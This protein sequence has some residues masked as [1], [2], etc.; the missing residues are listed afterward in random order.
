MLIYMLAVSGILIH[1]HYCG[2]QL[3]SWNVYSISKGCVDKDC[4]DEGGRPDNCCKDKVIAAK[5]VHDQ[6]VSQAFS[7]QFATSAILPANPFYSVRYQEEPFEEA[8]VNVYQANA[9]PGPWQQIPLYKLFSSFT[10]YS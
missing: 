9:P 3:S 1:M 8:V 5:V 6:N 10:Y 2:K 4:G 7:F